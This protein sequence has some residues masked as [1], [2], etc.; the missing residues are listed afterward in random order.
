MKARVRVL[1]L[2]ACLVFALLPLSHANARRA[3][4]SIQLNLKGY[5]NL[6]TLKI[7]VPYPVSDE[8]QII[9]NVKIE[10]NFSNKSINKEDKYGNTALYAEWDNV[11]S[12]KVLLFTFQVKREEVIKKDFPQEESSF[13]RKEFKSYLKAT[14][15]GPVTGNVKALTKKITKGRKSNLAKARAIYEWVIGNMYRDPNVKGCGLGDVNRLIARKG[16]KCAD[17]NSVFVS[18]CKSAGV[19]A[20]EIFGIRIPKGSQGDITK[21]QHCWAEFYMPGYGWVPVDPADVTKAILEKNIVDINDAQSIIEYFF[22]AIDENRIAYQAGR[23]LI[24]APAQKAGELNYFMYP[25]AEGDG[26]ILNEDIY[27]FNL[28]YKISFREL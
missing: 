1:A 16:G 21:S 27:G 5:E 8:N 9:E 11:S 17:I 7:W 24:L 10:G 6:N 12:E 13:F 3:E 20:R 26:E 22:G 2:L 19:P 4:V 18:L 14:K 23:D 25:Y 15:L 28:G